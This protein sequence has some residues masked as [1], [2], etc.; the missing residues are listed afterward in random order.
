VVTTSNA[1]SLARPVVT[2]F[3]DAMGLRGRLQENAFQINGFS[4][5]KFR[6]FM[7]NLIGNVLKP[8]YLEIGLFHGA[9][10]CPAIFKNRVR[11]VGVDNWTEYGG[12]RTIFEENL[13]QFKSEGADVEIIQKDF[14]EVDY[15]ALAPFNILFYDGSHQEVDQYDGI[16]T[17]QSGMADQYILIVDDWNWLHV[18]R[19]TFNAL[20]DVN[21]RIDFQIEVRTSF[22]DEHLPLIHGPSSDWHNGCII[23]AVTK[24]H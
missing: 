7:N 10:F 19:G 22:N 23:A 21:V 16:V 12:T 14:R 15:A 9:S 5:R 13:A 11:A 17:P 6:L 8:S 1:N 24:I 3:E 20:R 4:G 2:A 18:Q